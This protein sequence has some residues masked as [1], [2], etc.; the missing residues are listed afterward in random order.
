MSRW[1]G[2]GNR[3]NFIFDNFYDS[4]TLFLSFLGLERGL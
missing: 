2:G 1:E 4:D 3:L